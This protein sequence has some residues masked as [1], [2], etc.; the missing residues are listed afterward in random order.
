[1]I[2]LQ[3]MSYDF[4]MALVI[5]NLLA[6]SAVGWACLC[7]FSSMD[8]V[9]TRRRF[10]AG[11]VALFLAATMSGY[12]WVWFGEWPGPGQIAMSVAFLVLLGFNAGNWRRGTP[13]YARTDTARDEFDSM[14]HHHWGAVWGRGRTE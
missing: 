12:S 13:V 7:R 5:I 8:K 11:Y 2:D 6:C 9:T 3:T 10:R 4:R 14:P 1:M